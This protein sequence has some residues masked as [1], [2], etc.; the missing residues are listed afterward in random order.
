MK[1]EVECCFE[2]EKLLAIRIR[3]GD[4]VCLCTVFPRINSH[5][6]KKGI[7]RIISL[8][9]R[10]SSRIS[11]CVWSS[12]YDYDY[13]SVLFPEKSIGL[14]MDSSCFE[15]I[16]LSKS[17]KEMI[18]KALSKKFTKKPKKEKSQISYMSRAYYGKC[19]K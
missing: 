14:T 9:N 7:D 13:T 11:I 5:K 18:Y 17:Q 6:F 12:F 19:K 2:K 1:H 15:K 8:I 16:K 4:L 3:V 10:N